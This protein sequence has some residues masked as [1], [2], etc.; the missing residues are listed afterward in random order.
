MEQRIVIAVELEALYRFDL[1]LE[2][3]VRNLV[4]DRFAYDYLECV[5]LGHFLREYFSVRD[6]VVGERYLIPLMADPAL[7]TICP[8][9]PF[10]YIVMAENP[11]EN[12]LIHITCH[13]I[14]H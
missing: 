12:R 9:G 11:R 10:L 5:D 6:W 4:M 3:F 2:F 14:F 1:F 8:V 13:R 7:R